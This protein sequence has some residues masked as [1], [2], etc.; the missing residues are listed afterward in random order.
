M[1][2]RY[3]APTGKPSATALQQP[4]QRYSAPTAFH[5]VTESATAMGVLNSYAGAPAP[6]SNATALQRSNSQAQRYSAP[7][8]FP[9]LQRPNSLPTGLQRSNATALQRYSATAHNTAIP[10]CG[11]IR[12]LREVKVSKIIITGFQYYYGTEKY[13]FDH[14]WSLW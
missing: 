13:G 2:Q 7:T 14:F 12:A 1:L 8:A 4:P 3:S 10:Q 9:A 6:I 5:S 11:W